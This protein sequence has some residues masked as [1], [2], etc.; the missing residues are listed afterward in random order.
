MQISYKIFIG[1]FFLVLIQACIK[2]DEFPPEPQITGVS[3]STNSIKNFSEP[4][5]V[6]IGFEDGDGDLGSSDEDSLFN[7]SI[8]DTRTGFVSQFTIDNIPPQGSVDDISGEVQVAYASTCCIQEAIAYCTPDSSLP[9]YDTL[10][11]EI[12]I[13]D[14]ANNLSNTVTTEAIQIRCNEP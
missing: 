7:L 5:T 11:L 8:T 14:R 13:R 12:Q 2:P 4:L 1:F 3:I 9:N 6:F 10:Y